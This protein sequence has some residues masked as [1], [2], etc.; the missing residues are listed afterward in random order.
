[1]SAVS[2]A[3]PRV[4]PVA[5]RRWSLRWALLGALAAVTAVGATYPL[6][7]AGDRAAAPAASS[8]R[9]EE[10][11]AYRDDV[12]P[13]LKDGGQVV[14]MGLKPGVADVAN[15][16]YGQEVLVSMA[17]GWADELGGI[18]AEVGAIEPPRFL[19]ETHWLF[20]QSLDGYTNAALALKAA[21]AAEDTARRDE[22]VD[23]A[24][25]LGEAA[26]RLYDR[27]AAAL[28]RSTEET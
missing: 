18:R 14:G 15:E 10:A 21:A 4:L 11:V 16:R 5:G 28:D 8:D 23:L 7:F 20:L 27:A 9:F 26:D 6:F 12:E 22:L 19:A 3:G 25:T 17:A 1:M 13:L 24:A 2:P